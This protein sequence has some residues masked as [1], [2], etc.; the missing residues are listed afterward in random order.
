M[1]ENKIFLTIV[2]VLFLAAFC[3]FFLILLFINQG[4]VINKQDINL[5]DMFIKSSFTLLGS[6][7]SGVIALFI[8]SLQEKSKK[9]EKQERELKYYS[10]IKHEFQAN[11]EILERIL[12]TIN[13]LGIQGLAK[14]VA[15]GNEV[16]E[17]LLV[18]QTRLNFTFYTDYLDE[19]ERYKYQDAIRAFKAS[20]EVY[21]YLDVIINRV[22]NPKNIEAIL[23]IIKRNI[24]D[25][26]DLNNMMKQKELLL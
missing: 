2:F 17:M 9:K 26:R 6:T 15:E 14:G 12:E 13:E 7:L 24:T 20:Y 5:L 1:K 18:S 25:I 3:S 19:L 11:F 21:K 8:F 10:Y 16:K 23:R 22:D 4:I